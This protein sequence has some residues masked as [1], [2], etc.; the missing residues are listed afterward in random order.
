MV[1]IIH[2]GNDSVVLYQIIH[3]S[4]MFIIVELSAFFSSFFND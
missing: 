4:F 3:Q 1:S 2:S